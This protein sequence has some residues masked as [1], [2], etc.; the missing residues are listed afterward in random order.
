MKRLVSSFVGALLV[1]LAWMPAQAEVLYDSFNRNRIDPAKWITPPVCE[2][3]NAQDCVRE[4][5]FGHLRLAVMPSLQ[6][7]GNSP[8]DP[9]KALLVRAFAPSCTTEQSFSAMDALIDAVWVKR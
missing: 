2:D 7:A 3:P 4:V 9:T 6:G 5:R 8:V 1:C